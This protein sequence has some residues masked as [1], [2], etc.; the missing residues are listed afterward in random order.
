MHP[1]CLLDS[2]AN[3]LVLHRVF[4]R[5]VQNPHKSSHLNGLDPSFEFCCHGPAFPGIKE[6][7]LDERPHQFNLRQTRD[8]P[9]SPYDLQ[10]RR[11]AVV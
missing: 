1:N 11:A 7:S 8:V 9:G 5:N 4:V 3:L 6:T 2:A 10:S